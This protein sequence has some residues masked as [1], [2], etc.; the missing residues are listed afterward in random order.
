M[1]FFENYK[2]IKKLKPIGLRRNVRS[3]VLDGLTILDK[4]QGSDVVLNKPRVQFL[5]IHHVFKDEEQKLDALLKRL[6]QNHTFISYSD[7]VQKVLEGKIDKPYISISS[8][9]GF[10]NNINVNITIGSDIARCPTIY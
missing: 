10:K 6:S 5:Y 9:D 2:E 3:F 1:N 7:A 8:D 4:V